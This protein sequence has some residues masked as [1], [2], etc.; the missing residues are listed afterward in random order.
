MLLPLILCA[1]CHPP[2]Y[3]IGPALV[4]QDFAPG[5]LVCLATNLRERSQGRS[6]IIVSIFSSRKAASGKVGLL[7]G[8][9]DTKEEY[10]ALAQ[11][12]A[13]YVFFAERH[14]EYI[15]IMPAGVTS[16]HSQQPYETRIDLPVT[17]TLHCNLEIESRCLIALQQFPYPAKL[18]KRKTSGT[19]TLSG[20]IT[21]AG[22]VIQVRIVKAES[23]S[24]SEAIEN[25]SS[26]RLGP[27]PR[28]EPIQ[29]TY[30]YAIDNSL[31]RMDGMQVHWALPHEVSITI[32]PSTLAQKHHSGYPRPRR[33]ATNIALPAT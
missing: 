11:P 7:S 21:R 5:S 8:Q 4:E 18:L 26:W 27:G 22:K 25:L 2:K 15:E 16:T 23:I 28:D 13:R 31:R 17:T 32:P 29:I 10:A 19:V 24:A 33:I 9:E 20:T 14:E 3:R 1:Q 30:S 12:H 6:S